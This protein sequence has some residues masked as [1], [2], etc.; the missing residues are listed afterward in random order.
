MKKVLL[1]QY[2]VVLLVK[3]IGRCSTKTSAKPEMLPGA[4]G[5]Y[6]A[7]NIVHIL[8]TWMLM[9][10]RFHRASSLM[11]IYNLIYVTIYTK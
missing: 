3:L 8:T 10:T 5:V 9:C 6:L 7:D 2:L 4:A 11:I 1:R